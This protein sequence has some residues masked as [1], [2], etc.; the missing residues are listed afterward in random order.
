MFQKNP[1]YEHV[2]ITEEYQLINWLNDNYDPIV[3]DVYRKIK[4]RESKINYAKYL[5]LYKTGGIYLDPSIYTVC[6]LDIIVDIYAL[7]S[8]SPDKKG[9]SSDILIFPKE[10]PILCKVVELMFKYISQNTY[11][12]DAEETTGI[13]LLSKAIKISHFLEYNNN[14]NLNK[15]KDDD[16]YTF[17][18]K[19]LP[20]KIYGPLFNEFFQRI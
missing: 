5:M 3:L 8:A 4:E 13:K 12:M 20:Y 16:I 1:H 14:V 15:M 2:F 11:L 17:R 18:N 7:V 6:D 9:Y 19:N 10:H